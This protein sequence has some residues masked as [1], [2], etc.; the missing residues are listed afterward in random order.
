MKANATQ[1]ALRI[2]ALLVVIVTI[3]ATAHAQAPIYRFRN[4]TLIS[5]TGGQAGAI[6]RFPNV[7]SSGTNYDAL[8]T[9]QNRVGN[10]TLQNIDRTADGYDEAFQPE[11]RLASQKNGYFD[12]LIQFVLAGTNTPALQPKV[13]ASGLDIDGSTSGGLAIKE[14]NRIDMGGGICTFNLLGSQLTLAQVGTAFDGANFTGILFGALVDTTA[15]EVMFSVSNVNVTSFTFRA[16]ADNQ[17][18]GSS[19]RYASLYF[20][21]FNYP[22]LAILSAKN[23]A[24]FSGAADGDKTNLRWTLTQDNI[25]DRVVLEKSNTGSNFQPVTEFWVNTDGDSRK[26]FTY[27]DIKGKDAA[28]YYR[29]KVTGKDGKMEYSNILLF[30]SQQTTTSQMAVYPSLVESA[31][32]VSLTSAEKENAVLMITDMSGRT[33]KQQNIQLQ[34]GTNS[35]QLSGFDQF[36]KGNYIVS[37][38]TAQQKYAKQIVV[39]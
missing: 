15:K 37:V 34:K 2:C 4:P 5:G 17:T 31:T 35:V 24:S 8:V 11:F 1:A 33:V 29:L 39:Q 25:A 10:I 16:G 32:T 7:Y 12:F 23:L 13:D 3:T 20:K 28:V 36:R 26:E 6:Y 14:Y 27:T 19:T 18:T 9:I 38:N 30:R 21:A 22:N